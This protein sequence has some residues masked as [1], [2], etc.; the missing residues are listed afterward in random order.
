MKNDRRF[1]SFDWLNNWRDTGRFPYI[2][3]AIFN[4]FAANVEPGSR[5][6]D[7]GASTGMS[8]ARLQHLG[9][10]VTVAE[11][12]P[13]SIARGE[14]YGTWGDAHLWRHYITPETVTDFYKL[15][16]DRDIEVILARRVISEVFD[17]MKGD[18]RAFAEAV[19]RSNVH[20]IVLE[21]R[22]VSKNTVHPCG[23]ADLE[24]AVFGPGWRIT[25]RAGD[26]R[27]LERAK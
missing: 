10:T 24:A 16:H 19:R 8:T 11:A 25:E 18:P 15:L 27:V 3:D 22:K 13:E 26:V 4:A 1:D 14:Q 2:H 6:L 12:N 21:G 9:Y 17:G 5:V 20:T 7:I 23:T